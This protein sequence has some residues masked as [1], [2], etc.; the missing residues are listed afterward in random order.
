VAAQVL[1]EENGGQYQL[2]AAQLG[3]ELYRQLLE[4]VRDVEYGGVLELLFGEDRAV[5]VVELV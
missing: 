1:E 3:A 5:L 2:D 4:H